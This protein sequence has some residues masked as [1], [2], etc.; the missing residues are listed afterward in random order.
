MSRRGRRELTL[1]GLTFGEAKVVV[2]DHA[3]ISPQFAA[4]GIDRTWLLQAAL[5]ELRDEWNESTPEERKRLWPSSNRGPELTLILEPE[6]PE[7]LLEVV[8]VKPIDDP[9]WAFHANHKAHRK[10][11]VPFVRRQPSDLVAESISIMLVGTADKPILARAYPGDYVPPLPWMGSAKYAE[12]GATACLKYWRHHAYLYD[13]R[14]MEGFVSDT[15]PV[16][17]TDFDR[18]KANRAS[19]GGRGRR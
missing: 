5:D 6:D 10:Q 9:V 7:L 18:Y 12:G 15:P 4:G 19:R 8:S 17:Y 16:W 1:R 2:P 3:D 13:R 14:V 11:P